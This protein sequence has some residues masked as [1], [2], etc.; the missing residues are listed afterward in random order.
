MKTDGGD[1]MSIMASK[2]R[3]AFGRVV[4]GRESSAGSIGRPDPDV[5]PVELTEPPVDPAAGIVLAG[6]PP[7]EWA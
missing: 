4:R 3:G 7:H 6:V 1:A 5:T 2:G